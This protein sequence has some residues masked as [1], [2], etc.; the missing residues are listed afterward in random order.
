MSACFPYPVK[1]KDLQLVKT[2]EIDTNL[3]RFNINTSIKDLKYYVANLYKQKYDNTM[4]FSTETNE[5]VNILCLNTNKYNIH[6]K[7]GNNIIYLFYWD[8][9]TKKLSK[10][11]QYVCDISELTGKHLIQWFI[12]KDSH[13]FHLWNYYYNYYLGYITP[14]SRN[15]KIAETITSIFIIESNVIDDDILKL[16]DYI[17]QPIV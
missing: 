12:K 14:V 15:K 11:N 4:L 6:N 3:G 2:A 17:N 10:I 7:H 5:K 9:I 8:Y 1:V 16:T 13:Q